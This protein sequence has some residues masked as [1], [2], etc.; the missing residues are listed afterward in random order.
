MKDRTEDVKIVERKNAGVARDLQKQ[1]QSEKKQVEKLQNKLNE[2]LRDGT[3]KLKQPSGGV[4]DDA[5][6]FTERDET[7][8]VSSWSFVSSKSNGHQARKQQ[9]DGGSVHSNTETDAMT[10]TGM[11]EQEVRD[12]VTRI[13]KLQQERAALMEKVS[14][15]EVGNAAMAQD[16]INKSAVIDRY[17][18]NA[19][20]SVS[21]GTSWSLDWLSPSS[22]LPLNRLLDRLIVRL[23][24]W[25]TMRLIG[26]SIDWLTGTVVDKFFSFFW[27]EGRGAL[28]NF[29]SWLKNELLTTLQ[30]FS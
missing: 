16:L 14:M 1:L 12:L 5:A 9:G 26:W 18:Q 10:S 21:C 13:T 7:G 28:F 19:P 3:L 11:T 2:L 22:V 30:N 4:M 17:L 8:S 27:H 23:I 25:L 24:D 15:L 29:L 20:G 6:D